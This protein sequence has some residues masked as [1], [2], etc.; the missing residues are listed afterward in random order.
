MVNKKQSGSSNGVNEYNPGKHIDD[1]INKLEQQQQQENL[2]KS[3]KLGNGSEVQKISKNTKAVGES[4]CCGTDDIEEEERKIKAKKPVNYEVSRS[5]SISCGTDDIEEEE[6]KIKAKKPVNYEVSRSESISC[7]TDDIEI[8]EQVEKVLIPPKKQVTPGQSKQ[9]TQ[10]TTTESNT[11]PPSNAQLKK[12]LK[13]VLKSSKKRL[14]INNNAKGEKALHA[15]A[16]ECENSDEHEEIADDDN[17]HSGPFSFLSF[18]GTQWQNLVFKNEEIP[19]NENLKKNELKIVVK[20]NH[21]A[22]CF[23]CFTQ[24]GDKAFK[25]QRITDRVIFFFIKIKKGVLFSKL[26]GLKYK[27]LLRNL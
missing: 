1:L 21:H 16:E 14:F 11:K 4:I 20:D 25:H 24:L 8:R 10:D 13:P 2:T 26:Y 27:E 17:E 3:Q 7:G 22:I 15:I 18:G 19:E 9:K 6:Q 23:H 12:K 5:E